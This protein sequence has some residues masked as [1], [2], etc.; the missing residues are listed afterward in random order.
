MVTVEEECDGGDTEAQLV[1]ES[2]CQSVGL[3]RSPPQLR[4]PNRHCRLTNMQERRVL[5]G[6]VPALYD[7]NTLGFTTVPRCPC[8]SVRVRA[9]VINYISGPSANLSSGPLSPSP[10]LTFFCLSSIAR[11]RASRISAASVGLCFS[12]GEPRTWPCVSCACCTGTATAAGAGAAVLAFSELTAAVCLLAA[13]ASSRCPSEAL[14]LRE[15]FGVR[16]WASAVPIG[17]RAPPLAWY[18]SAQTASAHLQ[19]LV[20]LAPANA[21][22]FAVTA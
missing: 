10:P 3:H 5:R 14:R 21:H 17:R 6:R 19:R 4:R 13:G 20:S 8:C 16:G 12:F 1:P 2:S 7:E 11:S 18:G 9:P 22:I 15:S